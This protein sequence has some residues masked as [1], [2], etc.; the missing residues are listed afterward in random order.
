MRY[1]YSGDIK[2][3]RFESVR[4][5]P[6]QVA[7]DAEAKV[8]PNRSN[9]ADALDRS[10]QPQSQPIAV[11]RH[12][13]EPNFVVDGAEVE[14]DALA[15]PGSSEATT[16]PAVVP[17][18]LLKLEEKLSRHAWQR[19]NGVNVP[20]MSTGATS[21]HVGSALPALSALNTASS[22]ESAL[23]QHMPADWVR[24]RRAE[25]SPDLSAFATHEIS[26]M[27][28]SMRSVFVIFSGSMDTIALCP[29]RN[30]HMSGVTKLCPA[31]A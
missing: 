22:T 26:K 10:K 12:V 27:V 15:E 16:S 28:C 13:E 6:A 3:L 9:D 24:I 25:F 7:H 30:T 4:E 8:Q 21:K 14:D 2:C 31:L 11:A 5:T 29:L 1:T 20:A 17:P 19:A 23:P 18:L